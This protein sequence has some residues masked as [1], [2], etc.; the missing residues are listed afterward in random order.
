M[1][2]RSRRH[3]VSTSG[4]G[5]RFGVLALACGALIATVAPAHAL[6]IPIQAYLTGG[7]E[8]PA[9][10]SP[11]KGLMVGTFDTDTNTL[12]WTVTYSGLSG[13]PIGAHFHGPIS[14]L[15]LTPEENAPIQVGTPG[16]AGVRG[17]AAAPMSSHPA[18]VQGPC[19]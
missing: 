9:N 2:D 6:K 8:V 5:E 19:A 18:D 15:G 7:G 4:K 10:N 3:R 17:D 14:Y 13:G 1:S 11:A 12:D 16:G